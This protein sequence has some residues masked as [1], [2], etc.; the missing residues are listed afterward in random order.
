MKKDE[1]KDLNLT[2]P[3]DYNNTDL[4]GADVVFTVT[5]NHVYEETDAVLDDAL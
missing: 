1:T 3:E 4:A 5:V 2:F